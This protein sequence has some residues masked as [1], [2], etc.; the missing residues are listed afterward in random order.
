ML[1]QSSEPRFCR[2]QN[3]ESGAVLRGDWEDYMGCGC[4]VYSM[5]PDTVAP[6]PASSP[7]FWCSFDVVAVQFILV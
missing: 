2:L 1:F 3:E 6:S 7:G 5:A 4:K